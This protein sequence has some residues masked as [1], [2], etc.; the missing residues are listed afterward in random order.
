LDYFLQKTS[1]RV[2]RLNNFF[3]DVDALQGR[4]RVWFIFADIVDC[5]GCEGDMQAFYVD[6][7][8]KR[9]VMLDQSNGI[10]ANA[11]LYDMNR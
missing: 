10:W 8:N 4:E 2:D 7:L 3:K 1:R 5:G 9:G 11:Y 6:E